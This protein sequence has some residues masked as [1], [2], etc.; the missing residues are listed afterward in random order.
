MD[1]RICRIGFFM[2]DDDTPMMRFD[3][4]IVENGVLTLYHKDDAIAHINTDNRIRLADLTGALRLQ[5]E[6]G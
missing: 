6:E 2:D 1:R 4:L 5:L 3:S